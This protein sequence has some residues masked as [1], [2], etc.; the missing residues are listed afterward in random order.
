M[1][2]Q[3]REQRASDRRLTHTCPRENAGYARPVVGHWHCRCNRLCKVEYIVDRLLTRP[4]MRRS[5]LLVTSREPAWVDRSD[6]KLA[7]V[8]SNDV[9][10]AE[11][12]GGSK[13]KRPR[14]NLR[15]VRC[16][17]FSSCVKLELHGRVVLHELMNLGAACMRLIAHAS[18][19]SIATQTAVSGTSVIVSGTS[20]ASGNRHIPQRQQPNKM[21]YSRPCVIARRVGEALT[22]ARCNPRDQWDEHLS[23]GRSSPSPTRVAA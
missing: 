1:P 20:R 4:A 15:P 7:G 19:K 5:R 22:D 21:G 3:R 17:S 11:N 6:N 13:H 16:S 23:A 8:N 2:A 9:N 12:S 14:D 18:T 10:R